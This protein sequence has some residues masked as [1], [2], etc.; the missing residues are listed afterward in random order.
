LTSTKIPFDSEV[1]TIT[2]VDLPS[3]RLLEKILLSLRTFVKNLVLSS[4]TGDFS[5]YPDRLEHQIA[6]FVGL[7]CLIMISR[8]YNRPDLT[9]EDQRAITLVYKSRL[10]PVL[11][12]NLAQH[13]RK[14]WQCDPGS[15]K[16]VSLRCRCYKFYNVYNFNASFII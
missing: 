16:A 8:Q 7:R 4:G 15:Y 14:K 12:H 6:P 5:K 9:K 10:T 1:Q 3:M 13:L 11:Q 2:F